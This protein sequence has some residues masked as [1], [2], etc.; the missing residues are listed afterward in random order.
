LSPVVTDRSADVA[1]LC[2]VTVAPATAAPDVSRT[3]PDIDPVSTCALTGAIIRTTIISINIVL[4][5]AFM[6][7]LSYISA[8][9]YFL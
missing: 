1:T 3:V 4:T 9:L 7:F 5:V 2:A 8:R 6:F